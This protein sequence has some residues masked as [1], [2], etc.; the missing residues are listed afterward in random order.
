MLYNRF[1][2]DVYLLGWR[3]YN[4]ANVKEVKV[5]SDGS[6]VVLDPNVRFATN[7][8]CVLLNVLQITS[9]HSCTTSNVAEPMLFLL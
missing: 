8:H 9:R 6:I 1:D 2:Q 7:E 5:P 4:D 3:Y